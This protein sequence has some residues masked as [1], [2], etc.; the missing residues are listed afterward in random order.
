[1]SVIN[2]TYEKIDKETT[3]FFE[4][5]R[6]KLKKEEENLKEQLKTEVTKIKE[7]LEINTSEV[8]NLIKINEKLKKGINS[9]KKEENNMIKILKIK[10]K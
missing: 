6:E 8:D 1:M 9:L 10:K 3:A 5:K 4:L 2:N 7:Q